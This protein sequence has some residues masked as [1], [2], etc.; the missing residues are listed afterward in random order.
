VEML[1][2]LLERRQV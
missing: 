2:S 1:E